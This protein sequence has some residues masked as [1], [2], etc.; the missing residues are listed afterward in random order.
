M[1]CKLPKVGY[2]CLIP[3]QKKDNAP[4][5]IKEKQLTL[6]KRYFHGIKKFHNRQ[7]LHLKSFIATY[8]SFEWQFIGYCDGISLEVVQRGQ[9][10]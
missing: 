8:F 3:L 5:F 7:T 6:Y 10:V 4:S 1:Q 9:P 2:V